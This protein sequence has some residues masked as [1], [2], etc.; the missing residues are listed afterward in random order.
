MRDGSVNRSLALM[1]QKMDERLQCKLVTVRPASGDN[2]DGDLADVGVV[3]ERFSLVDVRDVNLN[4]RQLDRFD[5]VAERDA[6]VRIGAR[7]E[8]N[9]GTGGSGLVNGVDKGAFRVALEGHHVDPKFRR[10]PLDLLHD[11]IQRC[12]AVHFRL[13]RAKQIQVRPVEE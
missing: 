7:I 3:S 4:H 8:D 13:P 10:P 2:A 5:G 11:F 9:P 6:R 12:C 1:V